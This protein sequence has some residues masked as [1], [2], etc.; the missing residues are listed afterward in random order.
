MRE[1]TGTPYP[2]L[3]NEITNYLCAQWAQEFPEQPM[4][5]PRGFY[6]EY[7]VMNASFFEPAVPKDMDKA[8]RYMR[9]LLGGAQFP[10][11]V[12]LTVYEG[13]INGLHR[14]WAYQQIGVL[15][16]PTY[17]GKASWE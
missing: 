1:K 16:V 14:L 11:I 13:V 15:S 10:P 12:Y 9:D 8:E 4:S 2:T 3:S 6:W 5:F 17:I 7:Q